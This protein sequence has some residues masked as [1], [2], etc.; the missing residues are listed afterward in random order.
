MYLRQKESMMIKKKI[1]R[2]LML[3]A[4]CIMAVSGCKKE[5]K[6]TGTRIYYTDSEGVSLVEKGI[7]I[8]GKTQKEQIEEVLSTIQKNTDN[9]DYRSPF[10]KGVKVKEWSIKDGTLIL[11]FNRDYQKMSASEEIVLRAAVVQSVGQITGVDSVLFTI[12]GETLENQ[13]GQEIGYMQPSDFVQNTGSSLHAYQKETFILY[14]GNKQGDRLV[15]E[16]VNIRYNSSVSKEKVL[17]EQLIKG[18]SS[19][20]ETAVIPAETKVLSVSVKDHICYVNLDEGFLDTTNVMN[21]EV[22]VYAIVNSI[23]E[24]SPISRVQIMIDGKTNVNYMGKISLEKPLSR[25]LNVVEGE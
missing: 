14:Y 18:P 17:V 11:D 20:D 9:I 7:R 15:K 6:I 2:I 16:K 21:P 22:P 24:G 13:N 4:I 10:V 5:G 25:N 8:K 23:I 3:T 1:Y 12:D 19:D